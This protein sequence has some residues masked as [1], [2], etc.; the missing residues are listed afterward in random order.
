MGYTPPVI[1]RE[2]IN[3]EVQGTHQIIV[4][5]K[6]GRICSHENADFLGQNTSRRDATKNLLI[7]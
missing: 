7:G 2:V 6:D 3:G 1:D 5:V 4:N